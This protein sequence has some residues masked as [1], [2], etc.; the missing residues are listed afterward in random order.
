MWLLIFYI[1]LIEIASQNRTYATIIIYRRFLFIY[2][3]LFLTLFSFSSLFT[4]TH[5]FHNS[6]VTAAK[7]Q[8][9]MFSTLL[10]LFFFFPL[11]VVPVTE[12]Q[13]T[14]TKMKKKKNSRQLLHFIDN[15]QKLLFLFLIHTF[16][17]IT[18]SIRR[19]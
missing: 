19:K 5:T 1:I 2:F 6:I 8:N 12:S 17:P 13:V 3:A 4:H 16:L 11:Y 9:A 7:L 14:T 18:H 10:L 15:T